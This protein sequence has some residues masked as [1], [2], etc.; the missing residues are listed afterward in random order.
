VK[1]VA[2]KDKITKAFPFNRGPKTKHEKEIDGVDGVL[3]KRAEGDLKN[4]LPKKHYRLANIRF[5]RR[6]RQDE[7]SRS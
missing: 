4:R 6:G 2:A 5:R 3:R 7:T 1:T